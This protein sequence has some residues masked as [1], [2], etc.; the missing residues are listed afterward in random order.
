MHCE[1]GRTLCPGARER[2]KPVKVVSAQHAQHVCCSSDEEMRRPCRMVFKSQGAA[3]GMDLRVCT[4]RIFLRK[5]KNPKFISQLTLLRSAPCR[6]FLLTAFGLPVK[7]DKEITQ[8]FRSQ[9]KIDTKM[10]RS[11]A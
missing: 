1:L 5:C 9:V 4:K 6:R 2:V 8:A 7:R 11:H 3:S 10:H